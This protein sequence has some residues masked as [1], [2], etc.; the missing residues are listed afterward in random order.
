MASNTLLTPTMIT[1]KALMVLHQKC[2]FLGNTNM[3]YDDRFAVSGAKIGQTLNVRMPSKYTVRTGATLSAQNHVERSTPLVCDSQYGVDV[4]FTSVELTMDLDDFSER[5]IEPA[6]AQLA[7]K[8]EG[9]C[10]QDAYKLIPNYTNATTDSKITYKYF[11]SGGAN[12]TNNLTP[13]SKR[14]SIL[15]PDSIVDFNDAVKG[16]FQSSENIKTAYREGRMGRT[17]GF[18]VYENTLTPAHTSGTLAGSSVTN[19]ANLGT[20]DTSNV[21][22]SQTVLSVDNATSGTTLLAGDIITL[23][24]IAAAHPETKANQG[25]LRSFVVQSDVTLTTLATAYSV[26]VKP[27]VIYGSGNAYQNCTLSGSSDLDG[28][29]VTLIGAV[30]SAFQNDIQMHK[31]AFAF[32]SADLEDVSQYGSWGSRRTQDGVS[33]R[34]AKQYDITNDAFPCRIDVLFGFDG[35]YA[36]DG[37]ANRHIYETD[38]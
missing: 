2:N 1:R 11:Q 10:L 22:S 31:D 38:F 34:I 8:L 12:L 9:D 14:S 30:G 24:T 27:A 35:L 29:A 33:M 13:S 4:S 3:Q 36:Q 26:T 17:G 19:G 18:D 21:W 6:M 32:V 7:A 37:L 15:S 23:A 16:L 28:H 5:I 25:K 20:S